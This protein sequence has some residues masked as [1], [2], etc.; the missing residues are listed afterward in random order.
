MLLHCGHDLAGDHVDLAGPSKWGPEAALRSSSHCAIYISI[1]NDHVISP[2]IT[3]ILRCAPIIS[4]LLWQF[5]WNLLQLDAAV[6]HPYR[7]QFLPL[8]QG[9]VP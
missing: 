7:W 2:Y 5:F 9:F 4:A 6:P 8:P 1:Y 3:F